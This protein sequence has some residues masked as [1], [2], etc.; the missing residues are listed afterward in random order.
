MTVLSMRAPARRASR[1]SVWRRLVAAASAALLVG[2][3]LAVVAPSAPA[4]AQ[5]PTN[6]PIVYLAQGVGSPARTQLMSGVQSAGQITFTNVGMPHTGATYNAIG[7]NEADGFI[8]G[9]RSPAAAGQPA[10]IVRIGPAGGVTVIKNAV[11]NSVVGAFGDVAN[12]FYYA[13]GT[14]LYWTNVAVPTGATGSI[15]L[16][17]ATSSIAPDMTWLNGYFWGLNADG[18][19]NRINPVSGAVT[20]FTIPSLVGTG[21]AGGAFTYGN[22][23]LG[24]SFNDGG[25]AQIRVT[26]PGSATPGLSVVSRIA[27]PS[28]GSNDATASLGDPT[29][30]EIVKTMSSATALRGDALD[31]VLT[32][33]NVGPGVSSG[34]TVTDT[35]PTGLTVGTLPAGCS[36]AGQDVTCSGG[37]LA[38]GATTAYEIPVTVDASA[39][40]GSITN[41]AS[42][43]ANESDP[44]SSNNVSS[45][46][47]RVL[48]PGMTLDKVATLDDDGDGV[49]EVGETVQYEFEVTNIGD[50]PITGVTIT[51]PL[52]SGITPVSADLA[53]GDSVTF[54]ADP[55]VVT[56][57]HVDAGAISNTAQAD[58]TT[59]AG[60]VSAGDSAEIL[61]PA[62]PALTAVKSASLADANGNGVADAGETITYTIRATNAGNVTLTDVTVT[63]ALLPGLVETVDLAPGAA[64]DFVGSYE[65]TPADVLAGEVVNSATATGTPPTGPTETTTTTE[66]VRVGLTVVKSAEWTDVDGDTL[67]E[68]GDEIVYTFVVTNTGN[69]TLDAVEIDDPFLEGRSVVISA[70]DTSIAPGEQ[71]VFTSDVLTVATGD[72]VGGEVEN[73][74][75]A[76]G[77]PV[78]GTE[79][80][81]DP[82]TVTVPLGPAAPQITLDKQAVLSDTNANGYADPGESIAYRFIVTNTGNVTVGDVLLA[83]PM[84]TPGEVSPASFASLRPG[85]QGVFSA[86][87]LVEQ[88]DVDAGDIENTATASAT[89]PL[90]GPD[91]TSS[92]TAVVA[93]P[94]AAPGLAVVKSAELDDTNVNGVADEGESIEYSFLVRNTGNVTLTG[95]EVDDAMFAVP[96]V[97]TLAPQQEVTVSVPYTVTAADV[98]NGSV[99]NSA[100]ATG[101]PPSG[102]D[103]TTPPSE[104]STETVD[105]A[106]VLDKEGMLADLDGDSLASLG[107]VIT[108]SFEVTNTGNTRLEDVRIDDDFVVGI[109][110]T[111]VTLEPGAT[112]TFTAAYSVTEDDILAGS[113]VNV[114]TAE[115]TVPGGV[116]VESDPD[117]W[118][119]GA[120]PVD[121]ALLIAKSARIVDDNGNTVADLGE[122]I[123][124]TFDVR[125]TGNV[126]ITGIEIVDPRVTG[127]PA[128]F[129]LAPGES[130]TVVADLYE[131]VQADIDAGEVYNSATANGDGPGGP[132]TS[133]PG[134][135]TVPTPP[136]APALA[137]EKSVA[138]TGPVNANGVAD[139]TEELT[140]TFTVTNT[141]NVTVDALTI[142]DPTV[143]GI[144]SP[145][146]GP[147]APGATRTFT[148]TY[149]VTA[150]DVATPNGD[151]AIVNTAHAEAEDPNGDPVASSLAGASV[152]VADPGLLIDKEAL[153]DDANDNGMA[154]AGE[155]ILYRFTVTN[156]GNTELVD[157]VIDDARVAASIP[158]G[159]IPVGGTAVR[160]LAYTVTE[161]DIVAQELVNSA[162][163]TGFIPGTPP[164]PVSSPE[165]VASV[166]LAPDEASVSLEK[167][168]VLT[169]LNGNGRADVGEQIV[170]RFTLTNTGSRTVTDVTID[171]PMVDALLPA[172]VAS[173]APGESVV[174]ESDPYTVDENDI[175]AEEVRNVATATATGPSGQ[176]STLPA[177]AIV[178]VD[179]PPGPGL[180][181]TGADPRG[182]L[183]G[184]LVAIGFGGLLTA[185]GPRSLRRRLT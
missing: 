57:A 74:A 137:L 86:A 159:T 110:P 112:F 19:V 185:F 150:A 103:I 127:L 148:A 114:A 92:D 105:P 84:F 1:P 27:G 61:V 106:L 183:V 147:L 169:D 39:P 54:V 51:D 9:V 4:Y 24:F 136:A 128:P 151:G 47:F 62:A 157:I 40:R 41:T 13:S 93:V 49:A 25:I 52:V 120:S 144:T 70:P 171:D 78:G 59:A 76:L 178:L 173:L 91:L 46:D 69:V 142:V 160:T 95:V 107:E 2:T 53:V 168:A 65:V 55:L 133:P 177:T 50:L 130:R 163:A 32:V 113:V 36:A 121:D 123:E 81:S 90:A 139:D 38:V 135:E 31:Y 141:G 94:P 138:I 60:A 126:T 117:T 30:L 34:H 79:I 131:V 35:I 18:V 108:Y 64:H 180:A 73:T 184:A 116:D 143:S 145:D 124:Y 155:G 104:T 115:G 72:I 16:T 156:T 58:G 48:V 14:T 118:S 29:D 37:R 164:T 44:V 42:V 122:H 67:V 28:S 132:V 99:E 175:A 174:V 21:I 111:V 33:R 3:G 166:P 100:T 75:T 20:T 182:W 88:A 71:L 7:F 82:S 45:A 56:Q 12:R 5:F 146:S 83:D 85:E 152:P 134:E 161:A 8:Y 181:D 23:N 97:G 109:A 98:A 89:D 68:E 140:Y 77:T 102:P 10:Q 11:V 165:D 179:V 119:I 15:A 149:I 96:P 26:N 162:T 158:V 129:D 43:L 170:Y 176:L 167:R 66:T 87:L 125:N 154:D 17:G 22:G 63:D 153:L 80:E 172:P 101:T 6:E